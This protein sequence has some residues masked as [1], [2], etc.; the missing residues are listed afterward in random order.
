MSTKISSIQSDLN[1]LKIT[2]RELVAGCLDKIKDPSG[3]GSKSFLS[4]SEKEI[5]AACDSQDLLRKASVAMP[6]LAG[7]TI[8]IKDLFDVQGQVTASGS[9]VLRSYPPAKEDAE[10]VSRLRG[11]GAILMGRT[12]MT[13]FA[14]SGLG[15][16]PHF[17]TPLNPFERDKKRIPGGSTSGGAIGV[18]DGMTSAALGSDTGGSCRIPAALCGL[19]GYKS[20]SSRYSMEGVLPLSKTLD[21]IGVIAT[22]VDCCRRIDAVLAITPNSESHK[23]EINGLKIGVLRNVVL[24]GMEEH[25]ENSY[26]SA[27][28]ILISAGAHVHK[29]DSAAVSQTLEL[30]GQPKIV[31]AEAF[32]MF[33]RVMS[34]SLAD[35]DPRVS[36]RISK[37]ADVS[38][39]TYIH[40]LKMREKLISLWKEEFSNDDIW[41]MPTVPVIAPLIDDL[42]SDDEY[43]RFNG[44]MLRNPGIFNFLDGCA[45]SIPCHK[46]NSAPVGLM[47][48]APGG[49]D[50]KLLAIASLL[51]DIFSSLI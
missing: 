43:F 30:Q 9:Q 5:L 15:L 37:G 6:P 42:K 21:S 36:S 25:V 50:D 34:S 48:V 41:V 51:E 4:I 39:A 10:V 1:E 19:V 46:R 49:C 35:I 12:N 33:H 16:N 22:S 14:Y 11:A 18:A 32:E 38:S 27:L 44:L 17:G 45:V 23:I 8:S 28:D 3:Q 31:S 13:E 20:T 26:L 24:D 40:A 2:T 47:L 7:A 29:I